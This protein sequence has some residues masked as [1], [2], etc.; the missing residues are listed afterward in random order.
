M[1]KLGNDSN[2]SETSQKSGKPKNKNVMT[3][4]TNVI[5]KIFKLM[6]YLIHLLWEIIEN[7]MQLAVFLFGYLVKLFSS[8]TTPCIVAIFGF[9]IVCTVA[10]QQWY[11]IGV[12]LGS[13]FNLTSVGGIGVGIA[14]VLLG[15]GINIYQ[16]AP[17]LWRLRRD[18]AEAY[19]AMK[20]KTDL[21]DDEGEES[22][23][24]RMGDWVSYDHRRLKKARR[25]SYV[26]ETALV[27]IYVFLGAGL[28]FF[29][30]IQAAISLMLP[31][32]CLE[33]VSST[34]SVLGGASEQIYNQPAAED[35]V[36][37]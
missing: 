17:Q 33:L 21:D 26:I 1:A 34:V 20:V 11:L 37:F 5:K 36:K 23:K 9:G 32:K 4:I 10:A 15:L 2:Q 14:G 31:E 27:I 28:N 13:F 6:R 35:N 25:V 8:P 19:Q 12:W 30:I 16:L 18:I 7:A 22:V 24:T 3:A 29:A